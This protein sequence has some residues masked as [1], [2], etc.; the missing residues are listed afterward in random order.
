MRT[1]KLSV[2]IACW[3]VWNICIWTT[4]KDFSHR[5]IK[6][7]RCA[8]IIHSTARHLCS[9]KARTVWNAELPEC[10]HLTNT[11]DFTA[12]RRSAH[13]EVKEKLLRWWCLSSVWLLCIALGL[14]NCSQNI[15]LYF[16]HG[17]RCSFLCFLSW[18]LLG[19]VLCLVLYILQH[20]V[21]RARCI[22][23][24]LPLMS[25]SFLYHRLV[26]QRSSFYTLAGEKMRS[27]P[28]FSYEA[29]CV[30]LRGVIFSLCRL[31]AGSWRYGA[32]VRSNLWM[33][34]YTC[35]ARWHHGKL[36]PTTGSAIA[37]I[38]LSLCWA[39]APGPWLCCHGD[40]VAS[41]HRHGNV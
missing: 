27:L 9:E 19:S 40:L 14:L 16:T 5:G 33:D 24:N 4:F 29:G 22:Y 36:L 13:L 10:R 1:A 20:T 8:T 41:N 18:N 28:D 11:C 35:A 32:E 17:D 26:C 25:S 12:G 15:L 34:D 37:A 3:G 6:V 21:L 23:C 2:F 7:F 38:S 30:S 31:S 39:T